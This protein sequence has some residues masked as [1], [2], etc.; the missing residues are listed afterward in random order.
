MP[1]RKHGLSRNFLVENLLNA[2]PGSLAMEKPL[3]G[4]SEL[5]EKIINEQI[6]SDLEPDQLGYFSENDGSFMYSSQEE[7]GYTQ[8]YGIVGL[9]KKKI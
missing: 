9:F 1:P 8:D 5:Q 2:Y 4:F 7:S 3:T 6:S